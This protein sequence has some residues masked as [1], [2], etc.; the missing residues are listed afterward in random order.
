MTNVMYKFLIYLSIYL[1]LPLHPGH[2][3]CVNVYYCHRVSTHLQL[4]NNNNNNNNNVSGFLLAHLQ[5]QVYKVGSGSSL[6]G[7][8]SAPRC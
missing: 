8:V 2:C 5:R 3:L 6:L 7:M 1:C 4:N